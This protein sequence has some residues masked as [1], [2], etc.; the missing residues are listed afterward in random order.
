[1]KNTVIVIPCYNEAARMD[2]SKILCFL[3][4]SPAVSILFVDDGSTDRT[5]AVIG[6]LKNGHPSQVRVITFPKNAGKAE[7][8]RQGILK[9]ADMD[10]SYVGFWDADLSTPLEAVNDFVALMEARAVDS[11]IG[12]RVKL[13]GRNIDRKMIRHYLGRLFATLA[14]MILKLPVY[15]TQCG[16]KLFRNTSDIKQLFSLPFRVNWSFDIEIIARLRLITEFKKGPGAKTAIIEHPLEEWV[17]KGG[18]KVKASGFFK[19]PWELLTL[20]SILHLPVLSDH[21]RKDLEI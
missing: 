4:N 9:A 8:V 13:L 21:Y 15:D 7:A 3:K 18:S 5:A 12:A 19:A 2:Q 14:S 11:V 17:H 1:M 20:F 6:T 16:A 10:V